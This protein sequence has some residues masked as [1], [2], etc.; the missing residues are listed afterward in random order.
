MERVVRALDGLTLAVEEAGDPAGRPVLV[1]G[2]TPGSRHLDGPNV[3]DAAGR[4][5]RLIGYDRPGYGVRR[6]ARGTAPPT[7][8]MTCGQSAPRW[9]STGWQHGGFRAVGHY[10]PPCAALLPDLVTAAA[11]LAGHAPHGPTGSTGSLAWTTAT[12]LLPG[13]C[14]PTRPRRGP[15]TDKDRDEVLATSASDLAQGWNHG[16]I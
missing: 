1:H 9:R 5:L 11:S 7:A 13:C 16:P 4:G 12:P 14:S 10:A 8:R 2:G 15:R 3:A 6:P